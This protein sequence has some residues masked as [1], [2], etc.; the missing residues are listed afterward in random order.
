MQHN[1]FRF[2][3]RRERERKHLKRTILSQLA[4]LDGEAIREYEEGIREPTLSSIYA[5]ADALDI[6]A[7]KL[8]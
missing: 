5:I 7:S 8:I 2:N 4:G 3:L 6:P 1:E